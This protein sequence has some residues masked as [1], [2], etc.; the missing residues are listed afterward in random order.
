MA[1]LANTDRLGY[2]LVGWKKFYNKTQALMYAYENSFEVRWIF[3]DDVYSAIDWSI[4]I[5]TSLM[6]V[7][8]NR[9]LQLR[10]QYD[11]L[12]LY[13]S[14]GAD[15]GNVLYAFLENNIFIDEIVMQLPEIVKP[16][17]NNKDTSNKNYYSEVEYA[18][19]PLLNKFK[20]KIHPKTKV[21]YQDFA[22]AG[23]A[24]LEQEDWF[25]SNPLCMSISVSGILRQITQIKD[26][27]TLNLYDT[28][29]SI[30]FVLG[31]DKPLV[32]FDGSS[33]YCYFMDTSTYHY[34]TPVDFSDAD[35]S[36]KKNYSTEFFY[37][38]PD[39]PEVIIKQAQ[40]IKR[41]CEM[42]PH[43]KFMASQTLKK[44][45]SEYRPILHPVIYPAAVT[46]DFQTEKPSTKIIRPMDDWF[47]AT[48]SERVKHNYLGTIDY[49]KG[50]TNPKHMIKNDISNGL[51]AHESRFYKL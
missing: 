13:F 16:T 1:I 44:H 35:S 10:E 19:I 17:L 22:K 46:V 51:T 32:Y 37:W 39:M 40:E 45:I 36:E 30:A 28:G 25:D 11:Y 49:L 31:V 8:K 4:P 29:K 20:N 24:V 50:K 7:Y 3:N 41:N 6:D 38:T 47:W 33:Y 21:R 43:A 27:Y 26:K 48:A 34:V 42:N 15:S 18:A 14:G 12:I 23:L 9:A 2:Y 5:E